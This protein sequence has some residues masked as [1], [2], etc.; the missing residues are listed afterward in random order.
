MMSF[1]DCALVPS[2]IIKRILDRIRP[3]VF[4]L[5]SSLES[6]FQKLPPDPLCFDAVAPTIHH[7]ERCSEFPPVMFVLKASCA[8]SSPLCS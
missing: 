5:G 4:P 8:A 1:E 3:G 7:R 6:P 2:L